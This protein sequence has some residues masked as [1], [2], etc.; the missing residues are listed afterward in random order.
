MGYYLSLYSERELSLHVPYIVIASNAF[1]VIKNLNQY[2]V[3]VRF[4]FLVF[5]F[6]FCCGVYT[7]NICSASYV[8]L[9]WKKKKKHLLIRS[10]C[11]LQSS[12]FNLRHYR[13]NFALWY[14]PPK[15]NFSSSVF[16]SLV[17]SR[18]LTD[19]YIKKSSKIKFMGKNY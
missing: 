10:P 5:F 19:T 6:F 7:S 3:P 16:S 1:Q 13:L 17:I 9:F 2:L 11:T 18:Q 15:V 8:N 4:F 12:I 14:S